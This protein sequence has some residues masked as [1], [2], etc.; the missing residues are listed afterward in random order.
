MA[1]EQSLWNSSVQKCRKVDL[2]N[3]QT[4]NLSMCTHINLCELF[5][6]R[7]GFVERLHIDFKWYIGLYVRFLK[8]NKGRFRNIMPPWLGYSSEYKS[9]SI[10]VHTM[11]SEVIELNM[12]SSEWTV[13][14]LTDSR[15]CNQFTLEVNQ[16]E[17]PIFQISVGT[18]TTILPNHMPY[19]NVWF[20]Y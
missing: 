5:L 8:K 17:Y 20:T 1:E 13:P 15:R 3:L 16:N 14:N 18:L 12:H 4:K 10:F 6:H 9:T 19:H 11:V 2:R 7:Q